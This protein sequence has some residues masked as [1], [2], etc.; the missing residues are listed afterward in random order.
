[1]CFIPILQMRRRWKDA[2]QRRDFRR[3]LTCYLLQRTQE[4][5]QGTAH[6]AA[7]AGAGGDSERAPCQGICSSRV[8]G[9]WNKLVNLLCPMIQTL[10]SV[11]AW[12]IAQASTT[13]NLSCVAFPA[14]GSISI[15]QLWFVDLFFLA[16][17]HAPL[18]FLAEGGIH[19]P[20]AH[21]SLAPPQA[22][23]FPIISFGTKSSLH[24]RLTMFA[25]SFLRIS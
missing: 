13:L 14:A 3:F 17:R 9:C 24:I 20:P 15:S 11:T 12:I 1:M 2:R 22:G 19:F 7:A 23:L 6:C 18:G 4:P 16:Q 5:H 10:R 8:K 25:S 21:C